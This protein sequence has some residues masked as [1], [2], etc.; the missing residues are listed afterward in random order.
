M[1]IEE[2]LQQIEKVIKRAAEQRIP[3]RGYVSTI[4]GCP[5][6]GKVDPAKVL[7]VSRELLK[8]GCYEISLGD[9]IGVGTPGKHYSLKYYAE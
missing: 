5:Y 2:S 9:T 6:D 7:D 8:L 1:T 3:V 4:I